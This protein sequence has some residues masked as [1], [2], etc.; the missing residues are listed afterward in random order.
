[1]R[2]E[3]YE[4]TKASADLE[5]HGRRVCYD[6]AHFRPSTTGYVYG[7]VKDRW[8]MILGGGQLQLEKLTAYLDTAQTCSDFKAS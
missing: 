5:P 8:W 3:V 6:C 7:C 4:A 2:D 1:M